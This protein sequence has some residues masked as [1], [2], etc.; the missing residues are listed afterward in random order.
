MKILICE[1][2]RLALKTLSVVLEREGFSSDTAE[3]GNDAIELIKKNIY[4]LLVV[5]I[6]LPYHSGLEL[7]KFLRTD[8]N[9]KTPVLIV[10]AFSD[11]QMQRQAGELGIDGYI[12]KPFNPA[13][14]IEKESITLVNMKGES[15]NYL[16][17]ENLEIQMPEPKGAN[18]S[19]V[20]LKSEYKPFFVIPPDPV[21]TV[22]GKWD[23]PFFRTYAANQ[24]APAFRPNPAPT[25]YGWWNHW[26]VA[27]IPG[28]GR[29]VLT[30]DKPG[31]FNLTTFVQWN[32]LSKT[33]KTR[34][35][36]MLQGMTKTK[37]EELVPIA[38]SWLHAPEMVISSVGFKGGNYD[39]AERAYT[40]EKTAG[41]DNSLEFILKGSEES[42]LINPAIII[43]N[44]G[45]HQATIS[46]NGENINLGENCKQGI[47]K[48]LEGDDLI[49]WLRLNSK[50]EVKILLK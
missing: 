40:L 36:I 39:E 12:V 8:L 6:H 41:D 1:D 25:V 23:S 7:I 31:H 32:D 20:N 43:K 29:W 5:D 19:F 24:A 34:T 37:A 18:I 27:Q 16:W 14:L 22:E 49:L 21:N 47:R 4:D 26:P 50:R 33:D 17:Y 35:R 42:P 44:W 9:S 38:K 2:N 45:K 3:N 28:D 46:I 11:M 15:K 13:D 30:P 10:T 48:S